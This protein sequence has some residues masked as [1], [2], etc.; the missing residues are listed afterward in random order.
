[1]FEWMESIYDTI[2]YTVTG[3]SYLRNNEFAL[4][5]IEF[6]KVLRI[7]PLSEDAILGTAK[8]FFHLVKIKTSEVL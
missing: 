5:L 2:Y 4:A 8:C 7:S 6:K 1:M 3:Q